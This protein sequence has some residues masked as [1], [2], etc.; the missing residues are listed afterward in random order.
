MPETLSRGAFLCLF[1]EPVLDIY[2]Y[3]PCHPSSRWIL[4]SSIFAMLHPAVHEYPFT[5]TV[6]DLQDFPL[7]PIDALLASAHWSGWSWERIRTT[8]I[9]PRCLAQLTDL[10]AWV[11]SHLILLRNADDESQI[12]AIYPVCSRGVHATVSAARTETGEAKGL[13][14]RAR[15]ISNSASEEALRTCVVVVRSDAG[16]R[17]VHNVVAKAVEV[18]RGWLYRIEGAG[19]PEPFIGMD[20][21]SP[22]E[23]V[24]FCTWSSIGEGTS[25]SQIP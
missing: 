2:I 8:W 24:G 23:G 17:D 3:R 12:V 19:H 16:T 20:V 15:K 5:A 4:T 18:A 11:T 22:L 7:E 1:Q 14:L 10:E 9:E 21:K 6:H 13:Y 25:H